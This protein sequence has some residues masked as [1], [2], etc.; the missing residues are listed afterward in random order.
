MSLSR[1]LQEPSF[2]SSVLAQGPAGLRRAIIERG[3][4][5]FAGHD[6]E[7]ATIAKNLGAFGIDHAA[8]TLAEIQ[9]HILLHYFEKLLPLSCSIDDYAALLEQRIDGEDALRDLAAIRESGRSTL[10]AS[11]HVGAVEII[12]PF[13]SLKGLAVA[14]VVRFATPNFAQAARE[15]AR[16]LHASGKFGAVSFIEIGNPDRAAALDMASALRRRDLLLSMFDE[17]N[18]YSVPVSLLGR[19]LNGGAGLNR[20]MRFAGVPTALCAAFMVR[21]DDDR[22]Q[23]VVNEIHD[24]SIQGL[25]DALA[26][27]LTNHLA[28]WYFLHEEVPFLE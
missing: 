12:A 7:T 19:R 3:T 21:R 27:I 4:A 2:L 10:L 8:A 22:Y 28:Q 26:K 15:R 24:G 23:F 25:Y 16:H 20:I 9:H 18:P 11:A 14:P 17:E 5:W 13:L 6:A 1:H